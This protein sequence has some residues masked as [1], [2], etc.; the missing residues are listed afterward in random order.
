[1]QAVIKHASVPAINARNTSFARVDLFFGAS[2]AK[3][4]S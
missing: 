4:P 3:P 1:M 2:E